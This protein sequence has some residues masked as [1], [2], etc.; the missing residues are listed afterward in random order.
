MFDI[1]KYPQALAVSQSAALTPDDYQRLYRQS[2]ED[3]DAF[4]A[5]QAKRLDWIKPW[6]S[7]QQCDLRSGEARWFDGAQLNVSY[8]CIDRH[9][10]QRAEQTALLWEGD[11]PKDAKAISYREL[12]R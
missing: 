8:N 2:V 10:A 1:R 6:S 11:D 3:P 5:E 7:V 4:W 12:H 9:L